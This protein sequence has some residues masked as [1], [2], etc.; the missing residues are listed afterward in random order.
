[1]NTIDEKKIDHYIYEMH[2]NKKK[3]DCLL[4]SSPIFPRTLTLNVRT[5]NYVQHHV[6]NFIIKNQCCIDL[7]FFGRDPKQIIKLYPLVPLTVL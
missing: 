5:G 3:I 1:M 2:Q 4:F 7:L 6:S